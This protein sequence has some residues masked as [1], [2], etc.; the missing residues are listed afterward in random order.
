MLWKVLQ[1][2]QRQFTMLRGKHVFGEHLFH[3]PSPQQRKHS[4][5]DKTAQ[6]KL[7]RQRQLGRGQGEKPRGRKKRDDPRAKV[8]CQR[9]ARRTVDD[10]AERGHHRSGQDRL[11]PRHRPR[12]QRHQLAVADHD[13]A[14][15]KSESE[16]KTK[17]GFWSVCARVQRTCVCLKAQSTKT[18]L[19]VAKQLFIVKFFKS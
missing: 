1:T 7:E 14:G 17:K 4:S 12:R 6:Q 13:E 15:K 5:A 10:E 2:R 11:R 18:L 8:R 3:A 9:V 16:K 19:I